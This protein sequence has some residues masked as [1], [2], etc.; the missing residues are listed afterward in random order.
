MGTW[1]GLLKKELRLGLIGF[2]VPLFLTVFSL[3]AGGYVAWK[4]DQPGFLLVAAMTAII[5]HTFYMPW[6][7]AFSINA[8]LGKMHL[9]LHNP[10]SG[11]TLLLAKYVSGLVTMAVSLFIPSVLVFWSRRTILDQFSYSLITEDNLFVFGL[12]T[13]VLVVA[14]SIY[15]AVWGVFL[16]TISRLLVPYVGKLRWVVMIVLVIAGLWLMN[17]WESSALF[18]ALTQW[19]AVEV[20]FARMMFSIDG[21]GFTWETRKGELLYL[22]SYVYYLAITVLVFFFSGWLLDRKIEV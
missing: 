4:F 3:G 1:A 21:L 9:W 15:L 10:N 18:E 6:Y 11:Y 16:W 22:G 20:D 14:I 12:E 13:L 7:L 19:G 17:Q 5:G 8:E 2:L